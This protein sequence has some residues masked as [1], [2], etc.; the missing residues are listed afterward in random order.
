M[1][2]NDRVKVLWKTDC[3]WRDHPHWPK[4]KEIKFAQGELEET[5]PSTPLKIG[6]LV[7][8]KFGSRWYST[9]RWQRSG[10]QRQREV[11]N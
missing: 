11:S 7:K 4:R 9:L 6:D 1:S 5:S 2:V 8:I 10:N 3:Q